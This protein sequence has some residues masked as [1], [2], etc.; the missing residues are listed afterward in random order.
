MSNIGVQMNLVEYMS[1]N[2][3][4]PIFPHKFCKKK[5]WF[6]LLIKA[7][8]FENSNYA[9]TFITINL[10]CIAE[11]NSSTASSTCQRNIRNSGIKWACNSPG[12]W[13][14]WVAC[15]S[16]VALTFINEQNH[17]H[18]WHLWQQ[19]LLHRQAHISHSSH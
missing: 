16:E 11:K 14:S 6:Y 12:S 13:V 2:F 8:H 19:Q 1:S 5:I 17:N 18:Q 4:I 10:I 15:H 3:F 7:Y 9:Y